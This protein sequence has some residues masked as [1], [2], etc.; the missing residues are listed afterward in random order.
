M[1]LGFELV[2]F[3][4]V[5]RGA[6]VVDEVHGFVDHGAEG[7]GFGFGAAAFVA[8]V[9]DDAHV[10]WMRV[11]IVEAEERERCRDGKAF[12]V[13]NCWCD[14]ED[15]FSSGGKL[16]SRWKTRVIGGF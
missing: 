9:S 16:S 2:N 5:F 10:G 13:K 6:V 7:D 11:E 15:K 3:R 4:A 1:A 8:V 14:L 12:G